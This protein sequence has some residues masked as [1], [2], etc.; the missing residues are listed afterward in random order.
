M[1]VASFNRLV[2][3]LSTS[4]LINAVGLVEDLVEQRTVNLTLVSLFA[5]LALVAFNGSA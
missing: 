3:H 4:A 2:G 5:I 1:N